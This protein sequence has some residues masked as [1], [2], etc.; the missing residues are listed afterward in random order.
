MAK[1]AGTSLPKTGRSMDENQ[2]K[3]KTKSKKTSIGNSPQTRKKRKGSKLYKKRYR[4]QG[5]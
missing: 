3:A 5:K 4:G 2:R 1:K